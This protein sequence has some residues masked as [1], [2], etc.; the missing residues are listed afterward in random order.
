MP[1]DD[2]ELEYQPEEEPM[3]PKAVKTGPNWWSVQTKYGT[4]GAETPEKALRLATTAKKR[5]R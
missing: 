1:E 3:K 5:L 2:V 4:V